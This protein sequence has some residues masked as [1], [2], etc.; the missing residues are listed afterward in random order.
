MDMPGGT[1]SSWSSPGTFPPLPLVSSSTHTSCT[2]TTAPPRSPSPPVRRRPLGDA[3]H[4]QR[5]R[6]TLTSQGRTGRPPRE[7]RRLGAAPP[8]TAPLPLHLRRAVRRFPS[9]PASTRRH[10]ATV[11]RTPTASTRHAAPSLSAGARIRRPAP[12]CRY[13]ID[14]PS[15]VS[16][17]PATL[18]LTPRREPVRTPTVEGYKRSPPAAAQH[19]T[20]IPSLRASFP[21]S[22]SSPGAPE[23]RRRARPRRSVFGRFLAP[24]ATPPPT[25]LPSSNPT[26]P[27][28]VATLTLP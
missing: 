28:P 8:R 14:A 19:L 18:A 17:R 4:A 20:T 22:T 26:L 27:E 3:P 9:A 5:R 25:P 13:T 1:A 21:P 10:L 15:V 23:R 11:A 6:G 12:L 2:T 7:S 24:R 16:H